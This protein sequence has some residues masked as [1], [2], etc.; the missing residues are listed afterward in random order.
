MVV[1][2]GHEGQASPGWLGPDGSTAGWR[3]DRVSFAGRG[4]AMA[5][6]FHPNL[7]VV[8]T[9]A[10]AVASVVRRLAGVLHDGEGTHVELS[11]A[12]DSS[13][14]WLPL[15]VFRP[16]GAR[17]R[18]VEL[19]SGREQPLDALAT[20]GPSAV[21]LDAAEAVETSVLESVRELSRLD[22]GELWDAAERVV[23]L[24]A[25]LASCGD[26]EGGLY[27]DPGAGVLEAGRSGARRGLLRRRGRVELPVSRSVHEALGAADQ[28]WRMLAGPLSPEAALC[29]RD[30][31]EVAQRLLARIG[32]LA[33]VGSVGDLALAP[34][35]PAD[36]VRAT[37][38]LVPERRDDAGPH[39]VA[40]PGALEDD[41]ASLLL[42]HLATLTD[43]RQ[44]V[45]VTSDETV[46][47]WAR[48]ESHAR[49]A[50]LLFHPSTDAA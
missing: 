37:C 16:V 41:L 48:L 32:A 26:G 1:D 35:D 9:D 8:V 23:A 45:V 34:V 44:I 24:R 47:D 13:S 14:G 31:A 50:A 6:D 38:A 2:R 22:Q 11:V 43:A 30:R 39:I 33:A 25:T 40:V 36:A 29:H 15:V 7:N 21:A 27:L 19:T 20:L 46:V 5:L 4:A 42:D 18:L 12:D 10:G 49:R 17:H 3:L 28:R